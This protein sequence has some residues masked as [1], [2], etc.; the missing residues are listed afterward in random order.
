MTE[1]NKSNN[2]NKSKHI[3]LHHGS[4]PPSS[5][6]GDSIWMLINCHLLKNK[7]ETRKPTYEKKVEK[8]SCRVNKYKYIKYIFTA[9]L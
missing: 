6:N 5:R 1:S 7:V 8:R 4:Q 9:E 3:Y 2:T